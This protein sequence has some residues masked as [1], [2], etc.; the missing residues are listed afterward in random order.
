MLISGSQVFQRLCVPFPSSRVLL[1]Q[2]LNCPEN[3][4]I[5]KGCFQESPQVCA[6]AGGDTEQ[7]LLTFHLLWAGLNEWYCYTDI[8]Q[9]LPVPFATSTAQITLSFL[10]HLSFPPSAL[11]C[12]ICLLL[13]LIFGNVAPQRFSQALMCSSPCPFTRSFLTTSG[14]QTHF[15]VSPYLA[16]N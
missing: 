9:S 7:L 6:Q 8:V 12:F 10:D 13:L 1:F 4:E 16:A 2:V 15:V 3:A 14:F 11:H 5:S